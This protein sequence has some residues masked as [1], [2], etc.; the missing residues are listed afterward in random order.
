[1]IIDQSVRDIFCDKYRV[2]DIESVYE[3]V[4]AYDAYNHPLVRYDS[5]GEIKMRL[6]HGGFERLGD[7][8]NPEK[9]VLDTRDIFTITPMEIKDDKK[10]VYV[11]KY[12]MDKYPLDIISEY[13]KKLHELFKAEGRALILMPEII[14]VS[15][16]TVEQLTQMRDN[17]TELIDCLNYDNII[18]FS[19]GDEN[20]RFE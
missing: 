6:T 7:L 18:G 3:P 19:K 16:F 2:I 14:D 9:T 17:L 12:A 15:I 5:S 10:V 20:E 13:G 11:A 4:Y 1:M 8:F